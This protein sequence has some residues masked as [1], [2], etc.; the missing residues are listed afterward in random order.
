VVIGLSGVATLTAQ[1][2]GNVRA[3]WQKNPARYEAIFDQIDG[4]ALAGVDA[5]ARGDIAELGDLMN[6]DHGLLN[7]LQVSSWEIEE[8]VEIARSNGALGAKLTGGGGGGAMIAV[9]ER[10]RVEGV[11]AAMRAAGYNSFITE[12]RS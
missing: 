1:T 6:I 4:L 8:L 3:A 9:A 11:A 2:V 7:A 12:I 10:D 5:L